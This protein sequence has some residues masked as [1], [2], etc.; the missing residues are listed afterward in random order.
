[1]VTTI[2]DDENFVIAYIEWRQ[3]GAS[4]F[5]KYGGEYIFVNDMWIHPE[6][7]GQ[8]LL[9]EL[10]SKVLLIAPEAKFCYY[11]RRKYDDRMSPLMRREVYESLIEKELNHGV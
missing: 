2:H 10:I 4:G 6:Y 7:R 9:H 11:Q 8:N 1:M 5:D 3:V